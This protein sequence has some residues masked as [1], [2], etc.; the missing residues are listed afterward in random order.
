MKIELK[1][2]APYLPYGLMCELTDLGKVKH[3]KLCGAYIDNSYAFFDT[4]ESEHGFENIKP[5]LRPISQLT[6]E[7]VIGKEKLVPSEILF[8]KEHPRHKSKKYYNQVFY[9]YIRT[10]H[11]STAVDFKI[12]INTLI[13][14]NPRWVFEYLLRWKFDVF[15][16]IPQGLAID[17]N[18]LV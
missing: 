8:E 2:L 14:Q 10:S 15:G 1:H 12:Y 18:S 13:E 6:E 7:I 17:K 3:A 16:L 5:I 4:V 9:N 11:N